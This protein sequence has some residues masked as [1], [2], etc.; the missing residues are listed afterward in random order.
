LEKKSDT[1]KELSIVTFFLISMGKT[2]KGKNRLS[3]KARRPIFFI[4]FIAFF[5]V[6]V[7]SGFVVSYQTVNNLLWAQ[8]AENLTTLMDGFSHTSEIYFSSEWDSLDDDANR[9]IA[10][11]ATTESELLT[12]LGNI[13][14]ERQDSKSKRLL[15]YST[16]RS[17]ASDGTAFVY[18]DFGSTTASLSRSLTLADFTGANG[19]G[20]LSVVFFSKLQTP[21]TV[22]G[23]DITFIAS[24]QD[25]SLLNSFFSTISYNSQ[26][27]FY[28]IRADG[29]RVLTQTNPGNVVLNA[30][31]LLKALQQYSF[32]HNTSYS[33]V[34]TAIS[35][36]KE[37]TVYV[38]IDSKLCMIS[39]APLQVNNWYLLMSVP[40]DSVSSNVAENTKN[41]LWSFSLTFAGI[42]IFGAIVIGIMVYYAHSRELMEEKEKSLQAVAEQERK[43]SEAKTL[44][45]SNMSHDIRTPMN[46]IIGMLNIAEEN[47]D[48]PEN[49]RRCLASIEKSSNHL[50]SLINDVLDMSRIE[51][52]KLVLKEEP[53]NLLSVL[54]GCGSIIK[55]QLDE[56]EIDFQVSLGGIVHPYVKGDQVRLQRI[57][58]NILGNA[59]KFTPDGKSIRFEAKE[60]ASEGQK[61]TYQIEIADTGIG[62][63]EEFQ[64]KIFQPFSQEERPD[65]LQ[66]KG[67]GLG[68]AITKQYVDAMGGTIALKSKLNEGSDFIVTLPLL[69]AAPEE[70]VSI[71]QPQSHI[72]NLEGKTILLVEDNDINAAIAEHLIAE[73]KAKTVL[74]KNGQIALET[75]QKEKEGTFAVILM[76][77]MMPI[78][79]GYEA[80]TAIRSLPR[81]DATSIPILA[82]TANAFQ[83]DIQ[84]AKACGMNDHLTKPIDKNRFFTLLGQYA[85]PEDKA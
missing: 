54:D 2:T 59:V 22:D 12:V 84:K 38:N 5:L 31:N 65:S 83:D 1:I 37:G 64:K 15:F 61:I 28:V 23:E 43:A 6:I 50:L 49:V 34:Q 66:Y 52:G 9:I 26:S 29:S 63:S 19:T 24:K 27:T 57:V 39:Y 18:D 11:K 76:D 68:M 45:L 78:M 72:P 14:S 48:D 75:F 32:D 16:G 85:C 82:M 10:S 4:G 56:R 21:L 35:S 40:S 36:G 46:G 74:A 73:T 55:G 17:L 8:R 62:M 71:T 33:Q 53:F 47:P 42:V 81:A 79:N 25:P 7:A 44:F 67:T 60:A 69:Q 13:E 77:V 41:V 58:I 51:A 20:D 3:E 30:F 80:T 70:V